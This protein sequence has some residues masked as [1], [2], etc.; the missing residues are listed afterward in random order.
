MMNGGRSA[1][2]LSI[3]WCVQFTVPAEGIA[4]GSN[5][6]YGPNVQYGEDWVPVEGGKH[7]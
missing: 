2:L 6:G 4:Q 1:H 5:F 7:M 3:S